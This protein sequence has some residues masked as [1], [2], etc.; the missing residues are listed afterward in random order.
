LKN[1]KM[2]DGKL[3]LCSKP[4]SAQSAAKLVGMAST[5]TFLKPM[6]LSA[7]YAGR[8]LRHLSN[9]QRATLRFGGENEI[10]NGDGWHGAWPAK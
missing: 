8:V 6:P 10:C 2:P 5:R 9:G 1:T 4:L 3:L 7:V